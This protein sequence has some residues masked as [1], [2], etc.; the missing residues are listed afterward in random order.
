M[1][2]CWMRAE[3]QLPSSSALASFN[4]LLPKPRSNRAA[5]GGWAARAAPRRFAVTHRALFGEAKSRGMGEIRSRAQ[6]HER[7]PIALSWS[8]ITL[9]G[10]AQPVPSSARHHPLPAPQPCSLRDALSQTPGQRHVKQSR[11]SVRFCRPCS[12]G[13]TALSKA[14]IAAGCPSG[15]SAGPC[16]ALLHPSFLPPFPFLLVG[17]A[18]SK[19]SPTK[20]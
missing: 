14:F 17:T 9:H 13:A 5:R 3:P 7:A 4:L 18:P 20:G 12:G 2:N 1:L 19:Q 10:S 15:C 11:C 6:P 8:A 16:L